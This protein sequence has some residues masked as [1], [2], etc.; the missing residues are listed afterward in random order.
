MIH[1]GDDPP[2]SKPPPAGILGCLEPEPSWLRPNLDGIEPAPTT[3]EVQNLLAV[4]KLRAWQ[5]EGPAQ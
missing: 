3:E 5:P 2:D 4:L 1:R